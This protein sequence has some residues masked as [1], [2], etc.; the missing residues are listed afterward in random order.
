M[1][2][3]ELLRECFDESDLRI[4]LADQYDQDGRDAWDSTTGPWLDRA[5]DIAEELARRGLVDRTLFERLVRERPRRADDISATCRTVLGQPLSYVVGEP[6]AAQAFPWSD[7]RSC[8]SPGLVDLLGCAAYDARRRGYTTI[9]TSEVVR[10]YLTAQPWAALALAAD[11]R[12]AA[13]LD[14]TEDPFDGTL[15]AS[16]CVSK[17]FHG[18]AANT[19]Q[20]ARYDE[21]DVF[22]DLVR[23]GSGAS[24]RRL[25]PDGAAMD[26]VNQASRQLG[27]GRVTRHA[28]LDR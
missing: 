6:P 25:V 4:F 3:H 27:I 26:R 23:F 12:D 2:L 7:Y 18:L 19:E 13:D 20:P 28:V 14:R 17:T 9:S 11:D 15:G 16:Y 1:K 21:H 8:M 24:V 22:L 10:V 5:F